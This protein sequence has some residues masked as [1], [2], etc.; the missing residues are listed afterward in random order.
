[1]QLKLALLALFAAATAFE[2]LPTLENTDGFVKTSE[3]GLDVGG[4]DFS[5]QAICNDPR[6]PKSCD[7]WNFCCPSKA[8][9]CCRNACCAKGTTHCGQD[10]H[11]YRRA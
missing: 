3:G 4:G 2:E 7:R 11:C 1:M 8:I 5:V 6:F 9:G 10:G